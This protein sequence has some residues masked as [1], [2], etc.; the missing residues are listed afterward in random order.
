MLNNFLLSQ[1]RNLVKQGSM[2]L[3]LGSSSTFNVCT[4]KPVL[5]LNQILNTNMLSILHLKIPF[6]KAIYP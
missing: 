1:N 2:L 3:L 5:L 6:L 4:I